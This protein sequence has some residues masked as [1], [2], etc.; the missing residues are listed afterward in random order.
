MTYP[1]MVTRLLELMSMKNRRS[2]PRH[3]GNLS[4]MI[5]ICDELNPM[6]D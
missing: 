2:C 1:R 3:K 4:P 5:E 6:L